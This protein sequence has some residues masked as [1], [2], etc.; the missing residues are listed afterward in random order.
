MK[1]I[2]KNPIQPISRS[3]RITAS[4]PK[5]PTSTPTIANPASAT[6]TEKTLIRFR[7]PRDGDSRGP[8]R[9]RLHGPARPT[10]QG[11][12]SDQ[13]L[14]DGTQINSNAAA[15]AKNPPGDF[16][17]LADHRT[18]RRNEYSRVGQRAHR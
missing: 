4:T 18:S 6:M 13:S 1:Q 11:T 15:P 8:G 2:T 7:S 3:E 5:W 9:T 17:H 14:A 10:R 16:D 12:R